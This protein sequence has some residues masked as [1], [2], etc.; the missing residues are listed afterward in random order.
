MRKEI[1]E[2]A[3]GVREQVRSDKLD[4][5]P[6]ELKAAFEKPPDKRTPEEHGRAYQA[7]Y[8][9]AVTDREVLDAAPRDA[10]PRLRTL[11]EIIEADAGK[12]ESIA[13]NR[14]IVNFEYWRTRCE[15]EATDLAQ[16]A[17]KDVYDADK[18]ASSGEK[19][20]EARQLYE[21]SWDAWAQIFEKHPKLI[22]NPEAQDLIESVERYRDL[23]GQLD[24]KF[25]LDFKLKNLLDAHYEGQQLLEQIKVLQDAKPEDAKPEDAKPDETKPDA[26]KPDASKSDAAKPADEKPADATSP[27]Q[28]TPTDN[29]P[30]N[31]DKP[32]GAEA[33]AP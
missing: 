4:N 1:D 29:T 14:G 30:D 17:R 11:V 22:D 8:Q 20:D 18:L 27:D 16:G 10:K 12:A 26:L 6:A 3:P 23:L 33:N 28:S 32:N 2:L 25:P 24:E 9:I 15:A 7:E 19:L 13:R 31:P 5:L 21:R